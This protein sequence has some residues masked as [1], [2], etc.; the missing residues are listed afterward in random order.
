MLCY[1]SNTELIN[2]TNCAANI[3][4]SAMIITSSKKAVLAFVSLSDHRIGLVGWMGFN[5]IFDKN[6]PYHAM[7]LCS[8]VEIATKY[9]R[10]AL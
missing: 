9:F 6:I 5:G 7:D 2:E 10:L 4:L 1:H 3:K 8:F